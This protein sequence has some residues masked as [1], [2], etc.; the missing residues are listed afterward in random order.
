MLRI[1]DNSIIK[2]MHKNGY[3]IA[4]IARQLNVSYKGVYK[5][6][7][8]KS[9]P[10]VSFAASLAKLFGKKIENIFEFEEE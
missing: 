10:S 9:N 8:G 5:V 7:N 1:K 2:E 3:S 4:E 6:I